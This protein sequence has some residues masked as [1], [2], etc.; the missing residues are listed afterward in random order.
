MNAAAGGGKD[1]KKLK[2]AKGDMDNKLE[3]AAQQA[4]EKE[5]KGDKKK[6]VDKFKDD[7]VFVNSTPK[8]ELPDF[9]KPMLDSY[10]PRAVEAPWDSYWEANGL[11][12]PDLDSK[13]ETFTMV[14][15]PP[16]VTGVL[17]IGHALT[18]SIED[19]ITRWNRMSGKNTLWVPGT[20]HAGIATQVVVE[21]KIMREQ[22]L[23]RHDLGRDKF[24]EEVWKYKESSAGHISGQ[25]RRLGASVDWSRERFTMEPMLSK[26]VT[27]AFVRMHDSGLIYRAN[28][29]VNWD[30][31][32]RTAISTI[33]V[34]MKEL[35]GPTELNVPGYDKAVE[36]GVIH[37]FSY[38]LADGSGEVVVATTRMETMLGDVAVAVHPDDE[39]FKHLVGKKLV[40]PFLPERDIVIVADTMVEIGFGTGCVKITPAHDAN[41]FACG[42][43]H[44][45]PSINVL[46]DDGLINE[47]GGKYKGY[48]RFDAR[49]AIIEELTALGQ[50][51]GKNPNP[52]VLS[53]CSRSKE[54][55]E[56]M[57]KPQ[58]WVD[59]KDMAARAVAE[60]KE[61][62]LQITPESHKATWYR[63]LENVQDWCVSRQLWW[64]HRV[65]A[66]LV[67]VK[68]Q[69]PSAD[70]GDNWVTGRNAEEARAN[71]AKAKNVSVDDIEL[72][73]DEDVLDTWFSS[74][75]FPFS[76]YGWPE[77]TP[78]LAKFYPTQLLETGH[79][80][81][82]F[83]VARMVMMG[84]HLTGKLP[85]T[86]VYLHSMVRDKFGDKMSKSKGNVIDPIDVID[87]ISLA[88]LQD[89]LEKGNLD[90]RE[91]KLALVSQ[92]GQFPHGI[93]EC[94]CDA[95]RFG[96]LAFPSQGKDINL[97]VDRVVSFRQ[98]GNKLWNATK[99]ALNN[100][101]AGWTR[102][103][104]EQEVVALVSAGARFADRWILHRLSVAIHACDKAFNDY[105]LSDATSAIY[106]FWL[107]ELCDV[108][109]E[110]IKPV[111]YDSAANDDDWKGRDK[112]AERASARATLFLC[113]DW[114]LRLLHPFM[115]FITEELFHR[116][117]GAIVQ[118]DK[119]AAK[120]DI[121]SI[122]VAHYPKPADCAAWHVPALD[123]AFAI[124]DSVAK[125]SRA[126]RSSLGLTKKRADLYIIASNAELVSAI[127]Q[128]A[129]DLKVMAQAASI[130]AL[131]R[132]AGEAAPAGCMRVV[133]SAD[134]EMAMPTAGLVDLTSEV[135]RLEK[136]LKKLSL[137]ANNL[138]DSVNAP[139]YSER[140]KPE[141]Q[142][143][144]TE[145]LSGLREQI[146]KVHD[147]ID[148]FMSLMTAEQQLAHRKSKLA[149]LE[150]EAAKLT[151]DLEKA[152]PKDDSKPSKKQEKQIADCQKALA[153]V[154]KAIEAVKAH[155]A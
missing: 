149:E 137:S 146:S 108:Y 136:E 30:C 132:G 9:S 93:S 96:L 126:T 19:C 44:N 78:E 20:D 95:L 65:P 73:Q 46:T 127:Q 119:S 35:P 4:A 17:H 80:I 38:K 13:A 71:A 102:P 72:E 135:V 45:L 43:R 75:L 18:C 128:G 3:K 125:Q 85:F 151:S 97:D 133:V 56:P 25:I 106:K 39:R 79:D 29:L 140:T 74:G 5:S 22:N 12:Q 67:H 99:F 77:Q 90:P 47:N 120:A 24:L 107:Y 76:V 139:G 117:P 70:V 145:K 8:G 116:L 154:N 115:P 57:L 59:C 110:V 36:F 111:L 62:R 144:H 82:F 23:T 141:V 41:D 84:L 155:L 52:M 2:A 122:M 100:F 101:P 123:A 143:Q 129:N 103:K 86:Q 87:G 10:V 14:I 26:A 32:L 131:N 58:W 94:G 89:K 31:T 37:S 61:G 64:G 42:Q 27:E 7:V 16:N 121:G 113:L 28:R 54:V 66:Y 6:G 88:Q 152:Q 48:K 50:Y 69:E 34:D 91:L 55:I 124:I 134:L 60:V 112:D 63:W 51:H 130:T 33:E 40:H 1:R 83:W 49:V 142:A 11:Y 147:A 105:N 81:L 148:N 114:G 98:F 68:G 15:P 21:K 109:L 92:K 153:A 138:E 53:F 118:H 104:D 150:K